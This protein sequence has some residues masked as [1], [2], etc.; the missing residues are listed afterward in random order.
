VRAARAVLSPRPMRN[1]AAP[2]PSFVHASR[3]VF[4]ALAERRLWPLCRFGAVAIALD[5]VPLWILPRAPAATA[6]GQMRGPV[7]AIV[8]ANEPERPTSL[9]DSPFS[10]RRS[11]QCSLA[12]LGK[13][14]HRTWKDLQARAFRRF[15]AFSPHAG[16]TFEYR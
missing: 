8:I 11:R 4:V 3:R 2:T 9:L 1:A 14:Q 12:A 13:D 6:A 5:T 15:R 7:A 16:Q 10:A